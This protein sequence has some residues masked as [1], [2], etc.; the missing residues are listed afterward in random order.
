MDNVHQGD[1]E[2]DEEDDAKGLRESKKIGQLCEICESMTIERLTSHAGFWHHN[3]PQ[4]ED[5]ANRGC[6]SCVLLWAGVPG[7]DDWGRRGGV[8]NA[9]MTAINARGALI[10]T[11]WR[12]EEPIQLDRVFVGQN[13]LDGL[14]FQR[15]NSDEQ[16]FPAIIMAITA[17]ED[18]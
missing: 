6:T 1:E 3:K 11:R 17:D 4:L 9:N 7:P 8:G 16:S 12:Y 18:K 5:S 10:A 15:P 13:K 14:Q 2:D